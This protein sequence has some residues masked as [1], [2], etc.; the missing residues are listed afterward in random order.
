[1]N[2]NQVSICLLMEFFNALSDNLRFVAGKVTI[3]TFICFCCSAD[4]N[5]ESRLNNELKNVDGFTKT[6]AG[7]LSEMKHE[8]FNEDEDLDTST[9]EKIEVSRIK[10]TM[11]LLNYALLIS[12]HF[13][14]IGVNT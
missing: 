14:S 8:N 5:V 12:Y 6:I 11:F 10:I 2:L 4:S 13:F 3:L 7:Y 9:T 1:M